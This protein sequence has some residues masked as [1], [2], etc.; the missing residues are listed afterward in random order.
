MLLVGSYMIAYSCHMSTPYS[1]ANPLQFSKTC[2]CQIGDGSY[3]ICEMSQP[4]SISK[5]SWTYYYNGW[6]LQQ[7]A[8]Y[9]TYNMKYLCV[10]HFQ[11]YS[12]GISYYHSSK[13][14][15][16]GLCYWIPITIVGCI[17]GESS[18]TIVGSMASWVLR[19]WPSCSNFSPPV[20]FSCH[21]QLHQAAWNVQNPLPTIRNCHLFNYITVQSSAVLTL[22]RLQFLWIARIIGY[23]MEALHKPTTKIY[24]IPMQN[25][26]S[27]IHSCWRHLGAC[28]IYLMTLLVRQIFMCNKNLS[29]SIH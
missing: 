13:E 10:I 15:D 5:Q 28:N 22:P 3:S 1:I 8:S 29:Y 20:D 7:V 21:S 12:C 23:V 17:V 11:R 27:N 2:F 18:V 14:E 25:V 16:S 6:L 24:W 9:N 4:S 26:A 19:I